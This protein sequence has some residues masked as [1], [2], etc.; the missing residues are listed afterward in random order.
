MSETRYKV[1]DTV[2][3]KNGDEVVQAT[4]QEVCPKN[5]QISR[6]IYRIMWP[7]KGGATVGEEELFDT[8]LF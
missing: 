1:G 7:P 4:V 8:D 3:F 2:Y 5:H 6:H